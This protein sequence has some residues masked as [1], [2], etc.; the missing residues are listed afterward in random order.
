[1]YLQARLVKILAKNDLDISLAELEFRLE[2]LMVLLPDFCAYLLAAHFPSGPDIC[3]F[4]EQGVPC[5]LSL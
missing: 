1:M 2:N 5:I 3:S 4:V